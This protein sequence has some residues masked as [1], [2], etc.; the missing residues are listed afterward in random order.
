MALVLILTI[1]SFDEVGACNIVLKG[2]FTHQT[3]GISG[4]YG[5]DNTDRIREARCLNGPCCY[6]FYSKYGCKGRIVAKG[7]NTSHFARP[8]KV[9]SLRL[10]CR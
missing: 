8:V 6:T 5:T 1:A 7:C 2:K 10:S 9:S 4:C 3:G